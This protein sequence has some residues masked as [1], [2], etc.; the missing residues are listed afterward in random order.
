MRIEIRIYKSHD[1]DLMALCDAGYPIR[2][3]LKDALSAYANSVPLRYF[4]DEVIPYNA[5]EKKMVHTNIEIPDTDVKTCYMLTHL[6]RRLRNS[7]CKA[8]LR[9]CLVQQNLTAYFADSSL[10]AVQQADGA[11]RNI[12]SLPGVVPLSSLREETRTVEF[13]GGKTITTKREKAVANM[14][15]APYIPSPAP[16]FQPTV[17]QVAQIYQKVEFNPFTGQQQIVAQ[18]PQIQSVQPAPAVPVMPQIQL[19]A[20]PPPAPASMPAPVVK[21]PEPVVQAV[22]LPTSAEEI[23]AIPTKEKKQESDSKNTAGAGNG[24]AKDTGDLMA[25]FDSLE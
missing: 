11:Y 13:Q 8:V 6:K 18:A 5:A 4:T 23:P 17:P 14:Q 7:F 1:T 15:P 16:I 9:N 22:P 25:M 24:K 21:E 2:T 19:Q 20:T 12:G 3:M 10:Y